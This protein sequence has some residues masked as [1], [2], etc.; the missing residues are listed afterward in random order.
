MYDKVVVFWSATLALVLHTL[1]AAVFG[2]G[3][4]KFFAISTLHFGAAALYAVLAVLYGMELWEADKDSDVIAAG[5]EEATKEILEEGDATDY[6]AADS[7]H[8]RF[9]RRLRALDTLGGDCGNVLGRT[10]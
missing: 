1:I 4:S 6:A 8:S 9:V 10:D 2:Y 5:R 7:R 3:I